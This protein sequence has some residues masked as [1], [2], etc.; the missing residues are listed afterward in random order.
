MR[1]GLFL[2]V[3]FF[4]S[5][6]LRGQSDTISPQLEVLKVSQHQDG[7]FSVFV[8]ATDSGSGIDVSNFK[9]I[10]AIDRPTYNISIS[11]NAGNEPFVIEN[12]QKNI[13]SCHVNRSGLLQ[14]G[15]KGFTNGDRVFWRI[16]LEDH[17]G[18]K[19]Y[20]PYNLNYEPINRILG[21]VNDS[22]AYYIDYIINGDSTYFSEEILVAKNTGSSA[23]TITPKENHV[24]VVNNTA[25]HYSM[26]LSPTGLNVT[27]SFFLGKEMPEPKS[28]LINF[29]S[30][31]SRKSVIKNTGSLQNLQITLKRKSPQA[32]IRNSWV[33]FGSLIK[34]KVNVPDQIIFEAINAVE[35]QKDGELVSFISQWLGNKSTSFIVNKIVAKIT[36]DYIN[37]II[38]QINLKRAGNNL[39]SPGVLS[40][41]V[42]SALGLASSINQML[43]F[44]YYLFAYPYDQEI[45]SF[46]KSSSFSFDYDWAPG[47]ANSY[48]TDT[49]YVGDSASLRFKFT[50]PEEKQQPYFNVYALINLYPPGK[51]S[52]HQVIE[53]SRIDSL[54][55]SPTGRFDVS[56]AELQSPLINNLF[57]KGQGAV[58]SPQVLMGEVNYTVDNYLFDTSS[59]GYTFTSSNQ[60]YR[61]EFSLVHGGLPTPGNPLRADTIVNT[62]KLDFYIYDSIPPAPPH[63]SQ[64]PYSSELNYNFFI[65]DTA[66]NPDLAKL[67]IFRSDTN[68]QNF[69]KVKELNTSRA[70]QLPF[71]QSYHVPKS[72]L[73]FLAKAV[74]ISGNVSPYSDT[75]FVDPD[76]LAS[77]TINIAKQNIDIYEEDQITLTALDHNGNPLAGIPL[78]ANS[79]K[80]GYFEGGLNNADTVFLVT[81]TAGI[82]R[83]SY[84][85]LESGNHFLSVK[86]YNTTTATHTNAILVSNTIS[87]PNSQD[88]N[89]ITQFE[90]WFDDSTAGKEVIFTKPSKSVLFSDLIYTSHLKEGL[91]FLNY[92]FKDLNGN[93]S[94][95]DQHIFFRSKDI[96]GAQLKITNCEYWIDS[97]DQTHHLNIP[98]AQNIYLL[99]QIDLD[100]LSQGLHNLYIRFQDDN[101]V[102]SSPV[103]F[104]FYL[105][106]SVNHSDNQ[107]THFQYWIDSNSPTTDS[108]SGVQA[109]INNQISLDTLSEGK[110]SL[111][112]RSKD[113]L[114]RWSVPQRFDFYKLPT[115]QTNFISG[116]RYW[117]ENDST[118][119]SYQ[120]DSTKSVLQTFDDSIYNLPLGNHLLIAQALD[121]S[122]YWSA[123]IYDSISWNPAPEVAFDYQITNYCDSVSVSFQNLTNY[124]DAFTWYFGDGDSSTI[125]NPNHIYKSYGQYTVTLHAQSSTTQ[126]DSTLIRNALIHFYAPD[127]ISLGNDTSLC[128]Q[129]SISLNVDSLYTS[130][131][132]STG[133]LGNILVLDTAT[134]DGGMVSV[135]A[136]DSTGCLVS[137][138]IKVNFHPATTDSLNYQIC[139]GDSVLLPSGSYVF[140][141]G[142]YLST[143]A[144]SLGCDSVI[145]TEVQVLPKNVNSQ[146]INLCQ[147]DTFTLPGGAQISTPGIFID[148]LTTINGCDSIWTTTLNVLTTFSDSSQISLCL[149][150]ST[151]LTNGTWVSVAGYYTDT[152]LATN[153]CDSVATT[154]VNILQPRISSSLISICAGDS[155]YLAG[156]WRNTAGNYP[157]RLT[158]SNGCDSIHTTTLNILPTYTSSVN[159]SICKGQTYTLPG[160]G[161]VRTAGSY[162]DTLQTTAGCDSIINTNLS[163]NPVHSLSQNHTLCFGDS[164]FFSNAWHSNPGNYIDSLTTATGCDSI[165]NTTL[166]V[167]PL[168][169]FYDTISICQYDSALVGNQYRTVPGI[170][171]DTIP[172]ATDCDSIVITTLNQIPVDTSISRNGIA[173]TA[174]A[175]NASY[176][177]V[178][179]SNG[180]SINNATSQSFT[181]I[182][183]GIYA[184][185]IT[186]K[187]CT[188]TSTCYAITNI[189]ISSDLLSDISFYP[190][191]TSS[192][193]TVDMGIA[194]AH[195]E[196]TIVDNAGKR[197]AQYTIKAAQD[198]DV[199][200]SPYATGIYYIQVST[201]DENKVLKVKKT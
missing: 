89:F 153:G 15:I 24:E 23:F 198:F 158:G 181:P 101:N 159:T 100:S 53:S 63:L 188:D 167:D 83:F 176:Q 71:G 93:F 96:M 148:S 160:N 132:W 94:V 105:S 190:N 156:A 120:A 113:S 184:C 28:G 200:L 60:P 152:L 166:Y 30:S 168:P 114:N 64:A 61:L 14:F 90:Y 85:P 70:N 13:Y 175:N 125:T 2:L 45:Y 177:W 151:Q 192:F 4:S 103:R 19:L 76:S 197:L 173:L 3:F 183:N 43:A 95:T 84:F 165:V 129:A 87:Y 169:V 9:L 88:S 20:Y 180:M 22:T 5:F 102:W 179:C 141:N 140:N 146:Q 41:Q 185:A 97:A 6:I 75:L 178:D 42:R 111:F 117:L 17:A 104:D 116:Y 58:Y 38:T 139:Q 11:L 147:G 136:L 110:H 37:D 161:T 145:I 172:R 92:R 138:T 48:N 194:F 199:D 143:L 149:G 135:T 122:G 59:T 55:F 164:I 98:S 155:I 196:V 31:N 56:I 47:A 115:T 34:A 33:I 118:T 162:T 108:I 35:A 99:D 163:V 51:D 16:E 72:K 77:I 112:F 124:A 68:Y 65:T 134:F 187:G 1:R 182:I 106:D 79:S 186:Q 154:Q 18:N 144:S 52:A 119:L 195:I 21:N 74:D 86:G 36:N 10:Y 40:Q 157:Q 189:G 29:S 127:S 123:P 137:D 78:T 82:A 107:I 201:S 150:D 44:N 131:Q 49:I 126:K 25:I 57:P 67:I 54:N 81:D 91:H 193:V 12:A 39:L 80:R 26:D 130:I 69:T 121:S 7:T 109:F 142:I 133:Y 73:A 171:T 66:Q 191:P 8:K 46:R 62:G 32:L 174:N 50:I 128:Q 27:G 170:Y